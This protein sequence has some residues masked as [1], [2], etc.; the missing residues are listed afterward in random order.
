M[1]ENLNIKYGMIGCSGTYIAEGAVLT[2]AHCFSTQSVGIWVRD[3]KSKSHPATLVKINPGLDLALLSVKGPYQHTIAK[4][5]QTTP[6]GS[7]VI[8]VGSPFRFEFLLSEGIVA[9]TGFKDKNFK[10]K[11]VIHTGMINSGSSGGGAFNDKGELVGV[12]TMTYG[13]PFGWAGI[14]LAVSTENI[15]EFLK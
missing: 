8:S 11:Y 10:S 6:I 12:N 14:S 1:D 2:A 4:I 9:S 13:N 5:A 7:A 15:K 3:Y